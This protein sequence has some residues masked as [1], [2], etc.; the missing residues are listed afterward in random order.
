M[1]KQYR[2]LRLI[3]S[4]YY[5]AQDAVRAGAE[6]DDIFSIPVRERIGRAKFVPE[7]KV[8]QVYDEMEKDLDAQMDALTAKEDS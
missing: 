8:S 6:I 4:F 7:D 1:N 2:M 5:K 3:M